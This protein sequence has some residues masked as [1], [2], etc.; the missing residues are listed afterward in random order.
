MNR[1]KYEQIK[2]GVK[3]SYNLVAKKYNSL[4]ENE[5]DTHEYDKTL[6]DEYSNNFKPNEK[7][8]EMGCGPSAQVGRYLLSKIFSIDCLDF[9]EK[10]IE[11][12]RTLENR[13]TYICKD[14]TNTGLPN[15]YYN[16]I[17]SFYA[18]FHIPKPYQREA[19]R[20]FYRLLK[21]NGK[22]LIVNHEGSLKKTFKKIWDTENLYLFANFTNKFFMKKILIEEGFEIDEIYLKESY[23]GFP[24]YRIVV[25]A[26][27]KE[28]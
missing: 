13:I 15:E 20:E 23:Y 1:T 19:L 12:A 17:V 6:L 16:G 25:K 10:C 18:L 2:N 3:N 5:L 8:C 24:K 26:T 11:N 28:T 22:L 7:I 4:F 9:S 14:M 21:P 27:K